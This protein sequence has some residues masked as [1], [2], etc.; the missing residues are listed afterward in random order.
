MQDSIK[1]F[2]DQF[3]YKP[4]LE[5]AENL[6]KG[7]GFYLAGMGGSHL[8]ADLF[9]YL[10]GYEAIR[11]HM[12]YGLPANHDNF[13]GTYIAVSYSGN[14]EETLSFAKDALDKG[15]KL[16]VI[17]SGGA[18][19]AFALENKIPHVQIPKGGIQPRVA[20]GL[21]LLALAKV[22]GEESLQD[23][24]FLKNRIAPD[25]LENQAGAISQSISGKIPLIYSS[26]SALTFSYNWKIRINETAKTPAFCSVIPE[27][28]HNELAGF[29]YLPSSA[30]FYAVFLLLKN[31]SERIKR[32][33]QLSLNSLKERGIEGEIVFLN[34]NDVL[35]EA[36]NILLLADLVSFKLS[37][38]YGQD[39]NG[40]PAIEKFKKEL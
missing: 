1:K 10:K 9:N 3:E 8:C 39:P 5:F 20:I 23:L 4:V 26:A 19:L 30:K 34:K 6:E 2:S 37:E 27:M 18:L 15:K 40:V 29:D 12:D 11:V 35:E 24:S 33:M 32:R 36:F 22:V 14:T 25:E 13:A 16:S 21:L 38:I 7:G 28:N 17:T 31:D